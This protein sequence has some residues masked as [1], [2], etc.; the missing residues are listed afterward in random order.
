[1]GL[2][3]G[4]CEKTKKGV[5]LTMKKITF[6]KVLSLLS[7]LGLS[8]CETPGQNALLGA[9]TGA[10]IGGSL[11]GRGDEALI[12]AGIGAGAG[13]VAGKIKQDNERRADRYYREREYRESPRR[14]YDDRRYLYDDSDF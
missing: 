7:M 8:A 4:P 13:Y 10:A 3:C 6:W 14:Y 11:H 2:S 12:G 1:M 5:E 9:A